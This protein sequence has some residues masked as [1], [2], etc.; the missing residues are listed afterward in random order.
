MR[1]VMPA[2]ELTIR[3][4]AAATGVSEG[5]LRMWEARHG[6]P[7]PRRLPSGHRRYAERDLEAVRAVL[8]AREGGLSL[9]GAIDRAR[10]LGQDPRP[11]VYTAVRERFPDLHPHPLPKRLLV[12]LSRAIEDE[13]SLREPRSVL[14]GSF[15][16]E[17]FYRA[18]EARWREMSRTAEHALVFADFPR[19][20]RPHGGPV[21]VAVGPG[22][23]LAREWVIVCDGPRSGA[24]LLG[25]Q[26]PGEPG[27]EPCFE[28]VWTVDRTVVREAARACCDLAAAAAPQLVAEVREQLE[29]APPPAG[30]EA[31]AAMDL[32]TRMVLYAADDRG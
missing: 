26:R 25:W 4:I 1:V 21:E 32:A 2:S 13:C 23:V 3:D 5:T 8:R 12:R 10:R 18:V 9:A 19:T 28:T 17:R 11:S 22:D 7:Q 29:D 20:R 30:E 6:F 14:F 16:R 31:R 27:A 24:C 15:Q